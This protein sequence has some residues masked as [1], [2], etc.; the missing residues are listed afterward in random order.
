MNMTKNKLILSVK[1]LLFGSILALFLTQSLLLPNTAFAVG[2]NISLVSTAVVNSFK[3]IKNGKLL[4]CKLDK[5]AYEAVKTVK[6]II[7]AYSSTPEETD[8][9]PFITASG[10]RVADGIIANNMLPFGT[11]VRIPS[12]FGD[13]I[14][15]VEDRM[16]QRK[17][18]NHID[19]WF[20]SKQEAKEFGAKISYIEVLDN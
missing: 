4:L 9:T 20:S 1:K 7:T 18:N 10:K 16:N 5:E 11:K 15:I 12:L 17:G 6:V 13:K 2:E 3:T 8:D 19:I 14:F